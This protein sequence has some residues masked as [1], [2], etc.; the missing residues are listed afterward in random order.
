MKTDYTF[1]LPFPGHEEDAPPVSNERVA[2]VCDGLGGAGGV[3]FKVNG[4]VHTCAYYASRAVLSI[5][6]KFLE[7]NHEAA[8]SDDMRHLDQM[9]EDLRAAIKEGLQKYSD[10]T[11]INFKGRKSGGSMVKLLPTTLASCVYKESEDSVDV[12][13]FW[14]GDS[15]CYALGKDGLHQLT[16]DDARGYVDA[17]ECI[18]QD[19]VMN[20]VICLDHDFRINWKAYRIPKPCFVFAAS[21]GC[22]AYLDSPMSFESVF[23]PRADRE[24]DLEQSITA[25]LE[26]HVND[27]RTLAGHMFGIGSEEEY[28][29]AFCPRGDALDSDYMSKMVLTP[30]IDELRAKRNEMGSRELS[31]EEKTEYDEVKA[32]LKSLRKQNEELMRSLWKRYSAG[33]LLVP[34][35]PEQDPVVV[36]EPPKAEEPEAVA[37]EA[38]KP[39]EE[40]AA[41]KEASKPEEEPPEKKETAEKPKKFPREKDW[42]TYRESRPTAT[43]VP[44]VV[45]GEGW[46]I[47]RRDL[48]DCGVAYVMPYA[49]DKEFETE[50]RRCDNMYGYRVANNWLRS[51]DVLSALCVKGKS[52]RDARKIFVKRREEYDLVRNDTIIGMIQRM[53]LDG[54]FMLPS[55]SFLSNGMYIQTFMSNQSGREDLGRIN[56]YDSAD[57]NFL[58]LELCRTVKAIHEAG[59]VHG[60]L[61]AESLTVFRTANGHLRPAICNFCDMFLMRD[62]EKLERIAPAERGPWYDVYCLGLLFY[63]IY[64]RSNISDEAIAT[65]VNIYRKGTARRWIMDLIDPMLDAD[66]AKRPDISAIIDMIRCSSG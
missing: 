51:G 62:A 59:L 49:L 43:P 37:A 46:T 30:R 6:V 2:I 25:S 66:P 26:A 35:E 60:S 41:D 55:E 16:D 5:A 48:K 8:F 45:Y 10:E 13:C 3:E 38:P 53:N 29:E 44:G 42:P 27:D 22:F 40:P 21:D 63:K 23:L 19:A 12:I 47:P 39:E 54:R 34:L 52:A 36:K 58:L 14:A 50:V 28:R 56:K 18:I 11:G 57:K 33:Y 1:D 17:M 65:D 64:I 61:S 31:P 15:R 32:E 20:N 7:E 9:A 4:E 24:F